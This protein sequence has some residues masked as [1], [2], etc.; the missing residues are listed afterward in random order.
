ML[1]KMQQLIDEV[2]KLEAALS[3]FQVSENKSVKSLLE[4][5]APGKR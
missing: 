2:R 1:M 4:W 5:P 3:I